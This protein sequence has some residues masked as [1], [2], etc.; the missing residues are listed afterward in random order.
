MITLNVNIVSS[1]LLNIKYEAKKKPHDTHNPPAKKNTQVK[2]KSTLNLP[3]IYIV[4]YCSNRFQLTN[5][6]WMVFCRQKIKFSDIDDR[7]EESAGQDQT[8]RMC[9]LILF[10]TLLK[11][12][13]SFF[14]HRERQ[15]KG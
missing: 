14:H 15:I 13:L 12:N 2:R 11:E 6:L 10:Y 5:L 8:A 4:G 3:Y 9:R 7:E 1:K